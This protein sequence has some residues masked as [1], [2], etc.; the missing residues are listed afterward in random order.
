MQKGVFILLK[1]RTALEP[2]TYNVDRN[3]K[4]TLKHWLGKKKNSK[5]QEQYSLSYSHNWDQN[6]NQYSMWLLS[7][8]SY[9]ETRFLLSFLPQLV[10][11]VTI[12]VKQIIWWLSENNVLKLILNWLS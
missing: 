4:N 1:S 5:K 11:R 2:C 12:V 6:F 3:L 10:K 9:D 7:E 8:S